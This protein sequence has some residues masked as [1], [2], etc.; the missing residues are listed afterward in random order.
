MK[1]N[2]P[3]NAIVTTGVDSFALKV[4]AGADH[5]FSLSK[6]HRLAPDKASRDAIRLSLIRFAHHAI[7]FEHR[8]A[9]TMRYSC[10]RAHLLTDAALAIATAKQ[11]LFDRIRGEVAAWNPCQWQCGFSDRPPATK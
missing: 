7:A 4:L 11:R 5:I 2:S 3:F 8:I 1:F 6:V 9:H 10:N